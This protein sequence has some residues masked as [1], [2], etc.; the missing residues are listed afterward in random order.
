MGEQIALDTIVLGEGPD[1][2]QMAQDALK[3]IKDAETYWQPYHAEMEEDFRYAYTRDH[4]DAKAKAARN[5]RP[6]L[7][8][9]LIGKFI[10]RIV[11]STRKNP[12]GIKIS[13]RG[14]E[15]KAKADV[16]GGSIRYVE[17]RGGAQYAYTHALDCAATCGKGAFRITY[18]PSQDKT[19]HVI[20]IDRIADPL[21]VYPDPDS[22]ELDGSDMRHCTVA[23]ESKGADGVKTKVYEH[24]WLDGDLVRW[25]VIE[26]AEVVDNGE[27]PVQGYGIPIY[28]VYGKV[29]EYGGERIIQG[30]TRELIDSQKAYNYLESERVEVIAMTPRPP[31]M[32]PE[33]GLVA[34]S[35]WDN[36][37]TNPVS[38]LEYR[39]YDDRGQPLPK[40]E[41]MVTTPDVQWVAGAMADIKQHF[42]DIT[43]IYDSNLGN[44]PT[45]LS[46]RAEIARQEAGDFSQL[47]YTEHLSE[48]MARAGNMLLRLIPIIMG[49]EQMI[50]VMGEDGV[51]KAI[52][53]Q[54]LDKDGQP[55]QIDLDPSDL[56][57]SVESGPAYSTRRQEFVDKMGNVLASMPAAANLIADLVVRNMDFPGADEAAERLFKAL[58]PQLKEKQGWVP[59]EIAD[60][61]QQKTQAAI[62]QLQ[63]Q[64]AQANAKA[65][66]LEHQLQQDRQLEM[67][68]EQIKSETA[69]TKT[70]M[71]Q[72]GEAQLAAMELGAQQERDNAKLAADV[73]KEQAKNPP[74][75]VVPQAVPA[76]IPAQYGE[77]LASLS[78][79]PQIGNDGKPRSLLA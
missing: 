3:R 72:Q 21:S 39:A 29:H 76:P 74:V 37:A 50:H 6:M 71:E 5:G 9:P 41:R 25:C 70:A 77:G 4:W 75:V 23:G 46:G 22:R 66:Q 52:P 8:V 63:Q 13:P 15:D 35:E 68:R 45:A 79:K 19:R 12:P 32:A 48:A 11:G 57:L 40:P 65:A 34:K 47:L 31:I 30:V 55:Y 73:L 43:G 27:W 56:D 16:F 69:L 78:F 54:G 38:T 33:G 24:Y 36:A 2:Q 62:Q 51:L 1:L 61:M 53:R 14:G 7:T 28:L 18:G 42:H 44:S 49:S 60:Q 17:S 26:G 59:Q 10:A 20:K 58:P 67:A 64:L